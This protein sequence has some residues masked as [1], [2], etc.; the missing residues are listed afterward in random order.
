[1]V[2]IFFTTRIFVHKVF[3]DMKG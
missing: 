3:D 2:L 1:M